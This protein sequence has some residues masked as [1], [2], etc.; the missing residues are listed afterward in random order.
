MLSALHLATLAAAPALQ[1]ALPIVPDETYNACEATIYENPDPHTLAEC[2]FGV[3]P[4]VGQNPICQ[5]SD[6]FGAEFASGDWNGDGYLDLAIGGRHKPENKNLSA[7]VWLYLGTSTGLSTAPTLTFDGNGESDQL[8]VSIAFLKAYSTVGGQARD[9]LA[10]GAPQYSS[11]NDPAPDEMS[12][13]VYVFL[14]LEEGVDYSAGARFVA[15]D[16]ADIILEGGFCSG[17]WYGAAVA[18]GDIDGDGRGDLLVGEPGNPHT[19]ATQQCAGNAF[20]YLA[21]SRLDLALTWGGGPWYGAWSDLFFL[22]AASGDRFGRDVACLGDLDGVGGEEFLIGA[23]QQ[24]VDPAVGPVVNTGPGYARVY[25]YDPLAT[26]ANEGV[27][28]AE[29]NGIQVGEGF[30]NAVTGVPDL[31]LDGTDDL[32]VGA[33]RYTFAPGTA[34]E[35]FEVGRAFAFSG[36][37]FSPLLQ[38]P[39]PRTGAPTTRLIGE[40]AG[41]AFGWSVAGADGMVGQPGGDLLIGAFQA[42]AFADDS[43]CGTGATELIAGSA[44]V[45]DGGVGASPFVPLEVRGERFKDHV[46]FGVLA[47][48]TDLDGDLDLVTGGM[49]WSCPSNCPIV[50]EAETGR[51]YLVD[52]DGILT[53]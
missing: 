27:L 30:G 23:P 33:Y 53:P 47:L 1:T 2:E 43:S 50:G 22:G 46:G 35:E 40:L 34:L 21:A 48:D 16:E 29:L 12:G 31:D 13:R 44:Y 24:E 42:D 19:A 11:E 45:I 6:H 28:L 32:L 10:I 49:A 9:A 4:L 15:A 51:V 18:G 25:S 5:R 20:A 17:S 36:A 14:G 3:V 37:D 38:G 41:G 7:Q 26:P 39:D 52:V 8:G